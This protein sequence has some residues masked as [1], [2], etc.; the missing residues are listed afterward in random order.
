MNISGLEC[1]GTTPPSTSR[2]VGSPRPT[3]VQPPALPNTPDC[4]FCNSAPPARPTPPRLTMQTPPRPRPCL[5]GLLLA[6]ALLLTLAPLPAHE[7]WAAPHGGEKAAGTAE[8]PLSLVA[9]QRRARELRRLAAEPLSDPVRIVLRGGDYALDA[10]WCVRP[11]DSGTAQSPTLFTAAPGETPVIDG[12][13]AVTGWRRLAS[14]D[15]KN[16]AGLSAAAAAELWVADAPLVGGRPREFRQLW[17]DGKKAVRARTPNTGEMSR[18]L[19]WDKHAELTTI[20][21]LAGIGGD[22]STLEF[23][24]YQQWEIALLRVRELLPEGDATRVRF[25]QPESRV[26]FEHPWPAPIMT[27]TYRAPFFLQNALCLL[28]APGEWFHDLAARRIYYRPRPGETMS[29]ARAVVPVQETLLEI[30][31]S[32]ER[33]IRHVEFRGIHFNHTAWMRPALA[34]HVPHQAGLYMTEAYK[35]LPPGTPEKKGLENQAW[36][37]RPPGAVRVEAAHAVRFERCRFERLASAGLDAGRGLRDFAVEGCVFLDIAGNGLQ[38]GKFMEGGEETHLPYNPADDREVCARL[39]IANNL[40]HDC[41]NEDWGCLGIAAGYI[42]ESV[43]EHNDLGDLPYSGISLGWGWTYLT[44]A[45]RDN[46]VH[47]NRITRFGRILYDFGGIYH[48]S[49]SPGTW[50]TENALGGVVLNP[51]AE[52]PHWGHIYPDEGSSYMIIR[53]NWFETD[54]KLINSKAYGLTWERNGPDTPAAIRDA[55]GLQEPYRDLL[56]LLPR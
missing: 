47:A 23:V 48:L 55:A 21:T 24:I 38:L 39:R 33:P 35:M 53:D 19:T 15:A 36:V 1:G 6:A 3:T 51:Y 32:L 4:P 30:V 14:A 52:K 54:Q 28:D 49:A 34:G 5:A 56:K 11:E 25:H 12:G 45:Q 29:A 31:G 26:Q 27:E 43:I 37:G 2:H 17:I 41:A 10:P 50:I 16:P 42:R 40:I 46:R 13:V 44:T 18:V 20:P 8:D 7:F 22:L 9:A